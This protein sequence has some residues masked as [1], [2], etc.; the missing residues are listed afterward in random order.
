M[1]RRLY[2]T[3]GNRH[4]AS[5]DVPV[6]SRIVH[7]LD[8]IIVRIEPR[9]SHIAIGVDSATLLRPVAFALY[10]ASSAARTTAVTSSSCSGVHAAAPV[11]A[12]TRPNL[13]P[14]CSMARSLIAA[15]IFSPIDAAPSGLVSGRTTTNSSLP[16]RAALSAGRRMF[17]PMHL[18]TAVSASSPA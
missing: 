14:A 12:V 5:A 13:P 6:V 3:L 17:S 16:Y 10:S 1:L 15:R 2:S 7:R 11:L 9:Q 4:D 18:A 8:G